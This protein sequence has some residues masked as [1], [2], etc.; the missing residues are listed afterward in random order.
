MLRSA[1]SFATTTAASA[2]GGG[3][4]LKQ[5]AMPFNAVQVDLSNPFNRTV[6]FEEQLSASLTD[7]KEDGVSAVWIKAPESASANIPAAARHGFKYHH[8]ADGAA[9]LNLWLGDGPSRI[10][11]FVR[12]SHSFEQQYLH[13]FFPP[14][15]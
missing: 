2:R 11:G 5:T 9:M 3:T 10:P 13:T 14:R 1:R 8:A 15:V 12:C 4:R 6:D 7:W